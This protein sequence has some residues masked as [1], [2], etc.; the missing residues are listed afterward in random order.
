MLL[1][2]PEEAWSQLFTAMEE[3]ARTREFG[4]WAGG[5]LERTEDGDEPQSIQMPYFVYSEDVLELIQAFYS[6]GAAVPFAWAKWHGVKTYARGRSLESAPVADAVRLLNAILR[7]D[8]FF[9]G[10]ISLM[11]ENGTFFAALARIR[12]WYDHERALL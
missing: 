12:S 6:L 1:R 7:W 8:R 11:L 4:Q 2:A 9:E 10:G 3:L 5:R